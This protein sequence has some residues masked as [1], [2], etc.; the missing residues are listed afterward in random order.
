MLAKTPSPAARTIWEPFNLRARRGVR[1]APF[2]YWFTYVTERNEAE[3]REPLERMLDWRYSVAAEIPTVRDAKDA[4]RMLRDRWVTASNRA[5]HAV[6]IIKDPIA[7]FSAEWMSDT[8]AMD[9]LVLIRHPA[10]F[11]HSIVKQ[12]WWHPF[13][14]FTSQPAMMRELFAERADEIERFA[15]DPQPLLDQA[16]L[17]WA[18]I[19][20]HI[21]RMRHRRPQWRFVR[22]EDLSRDPVGGFRDLYGWLGLEWSD[23]VERAIVESSSEGNPSV[24]TQAADRKRDSKAAITTWKTRLTPDE[25]A[26]IRERTFPV[27]K[28]FY[29]DDDW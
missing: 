27:W 23:D 10:A 15:R 4:G 26:L 18:L 2:R 14:H 1:Q 5:A 19:H 22:H 13:D 21:A 17:L 11:A 3:F 29:G 9:T 24:T 25:Q 16:I 20:E 28:E 8:F 12:G 7:V 6:P